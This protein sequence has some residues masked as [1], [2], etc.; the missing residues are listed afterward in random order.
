MRI[1][2]SRTFF[3]DWPLVKCCPEIAVDLKS[4]RSQSCAVTSCPKRPTQKISL[5][6]RKN[7]RLHWSKLPKKMYLYLYT[8]IFLSNIQHPLRYHYRSIRLTAID[9]LKRMG[10]S[11]YLWMFLDISITVRF[12]SAWLIYFLGRSEV[13]TWAR[14]KKTTKQPLFHALNMLSL[15]TKASEKSVLPNNVCI[16]QTQVRR[17]G[18]PVG[19]TF[20]AVLTQFRCQWMQCYGVGFP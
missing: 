7:I 18:G 4:C 10:A 6:I 13:T 3:L 20:S 12:T 1:Y 2:T 19:L 17:S 5:K 15:F 14:I 16:W 8:N 9:W 11:D